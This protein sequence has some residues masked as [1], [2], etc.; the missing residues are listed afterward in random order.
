MLSKIRDSL[1]ILKNAEMSPIFK[2][3]E[4][5]IKNNYRPVCIFI[6]IL[7][8]IWNNSDCPTNGIV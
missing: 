2:K 7:K 1:M 5:M 3:N 4:D 8:S 6:S